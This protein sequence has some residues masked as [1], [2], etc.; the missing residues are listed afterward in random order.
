V[1]ARRRNHLAEST[2]RTYQSRL[3]RQLNAIM[4][5]APTNS[6]GRR[7]RKRYGKLRG[8]LFTFLEHPEVPPDNNDSERELRPTATWGQAIER[9]G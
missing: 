7:L 4:V 6:H 3:D 1:L 9:A 5:L 8:H 2:R